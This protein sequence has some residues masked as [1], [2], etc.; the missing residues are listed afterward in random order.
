MVLAHLGLAVFVAGVT[1]VNTFESSQ[2]LQMRPGDSYAVGDYTFR[3]DSTRSIRGSNYRGTEARIEVS[4]NGK[5]VF[6]MHP[7][8]RVYDAQRSPTTEAAI[9]GGVFRDMFVALGE[10]LGNGAWSLR[11]R[12]KPLVRWVWFGALMM[13]L[14]GVVCI[15]D[16][17]YRRLLARDAARQQA[18]VGGRLS[19]AGT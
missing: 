6:V 14:G 18:S 13:A 1:A 11:V 12:L 17:R 9:D 7:Q 5:L 10:P 15:T 8:K 2:D 4:H 16:P 3:F 19:E